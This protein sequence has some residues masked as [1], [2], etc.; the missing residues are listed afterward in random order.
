MAMYGI[1]RTAKTRLSRLIMFCREKIAARETRG[2]K[3][4][5]LGLERLRGRFKG[6]RRR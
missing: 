4:A 1:A 3:A 6:E 5:E 2:E